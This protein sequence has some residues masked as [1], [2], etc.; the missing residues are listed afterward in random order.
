ME[1]NNDTGFSC[2]MILYYLFIVWY[3]LASPRGYC[4]SIFC[5]FLKEVKCINKKIKLMKMGWTNKFLNFTISFTC[6]L[7]FFYFSFFCR[8]LGGHVLCILVIVFRHLI[9]ALCS[10]I[11]MIFR[12]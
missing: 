5:I 11:D 1:Q 12:L 7:F 9:V 8:C 3:E 2:K 4:T 10:Y 6:C